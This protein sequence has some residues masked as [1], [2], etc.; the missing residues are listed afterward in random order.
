MAL[1]I[2]GRMR[3]PALTVTFGTWAIAITMGILVA[4]QQHAGPVDRWLTQ[5]VHAV[6]G[7]RGRLAELLLVPTDTPVIAAAVLAIVVAALA[8][9]RWDVALLAAGTPV[10]GVGLVELALKPL[11][12]RRLHGYLSYP[13][14]HAVAAMTVYT[15]AALAVTST[16]GP[17]RRCLATAGWGLLAVV[18]M[19]GLV[20]M[21]CHYP[22]DTVGGVCVAIGITLPCA[23]GIDR[24]V[25]RDR[26]AIQI[27]R[28]RSESPAVTR[29]SPAGTTR[30][31][32]A[33]HTT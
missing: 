12:D 10:L 22:T 2:S 9:R 16:G 19:V 6:F 4:G 27:P 13:S 30:E 20:A 26:S 32:T 17:L 29:N 31:H 14:G 7:N 8:R 23:L 11:F 5:W 24:C 1:V 18:V 21:D 28:Q 33:D 15:V 25:R 3:V